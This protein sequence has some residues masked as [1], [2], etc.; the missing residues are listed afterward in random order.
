MTHQPDE[1]WGVLDIGGYAAIY[2]P[3]LDPTISTI[4]YRG[5][6]EGAEVLGLRT[7]EKPVFELEWPRYTDLGTALFFCMSAGGYWPKG[8]EFL[9]I[10]ADRSLTPS[11]EV[12]SLIFKMF[13]AD[14]ITDNEFY[15]MGAI[16][17]DFGAPGDDRI[18]VTQSGHIAI[19]LWES[20]LLPFKQGR[21]NPDYSFSSQE[22]LADIVSGKATKRVHDKFLAL[23]PTDHPWHDRADE[24]STSGV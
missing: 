4:Q 9:K 6:V 17:S 2:T 15:V 5:Y 24:S 12:R 16:K 3:V 13:P 19:A 18:Q 22:F 7:F 21:R 1:T 20:A 11:H 10:L 23:L 8:I 14:R